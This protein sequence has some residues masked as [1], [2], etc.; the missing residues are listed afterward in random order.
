MM[1]VSYKP[2]DYPV[3]RMSVTIGMSEDG[4]TGGF[5]ATFI[6]NVVG[7]PSPKDPLGYAG[8]LGRDFLRFV[9]LTYDGPKAEY[10]LVHYKHASAPMQKAPPLGG[11]KGIDR[12][13]RAGRKQKGR[14]Y[15]GK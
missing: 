6:T 13:R 4:R 7:T 11:W 8:L 10:E 2:E 1:G 5:Q 9:R 15:P 12:A 3:Y 14:R